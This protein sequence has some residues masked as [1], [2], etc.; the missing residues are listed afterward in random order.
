MRPSSALV[1]AL[2]LSGCDAPGLRAPP[3][4][5][6]TTAAAS[7][8]PTKP[9]DIAWGTAIKWHE[10]DAAQRIAAAENKPVCVVVYADWCPLCK[11]LAPEFTKPELV[12]AAA[13]LVMVRQD[14]DDKPAWLEQ[15]LGKYGNYLP[16]VLFLDPNGSVREDLQSGHPRFPYFYAS[17]V[18]DRLIANM[19][20]AAASS[21]H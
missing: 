17:M 15:R 9:A 12:R 13:G 19:R 2:A 6:P 1:L 20:A 3:P 11:E 10:W 14:Q 4:P 5:E 7:P 21:R 8:T 18:S 16:R